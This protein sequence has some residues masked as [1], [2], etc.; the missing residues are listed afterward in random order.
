ML[1]WHPFY[2]WST[3][4][5]LVPLQIQGMLSPTVVNKLKAKHHFAITQRLLL[6]HMNLVFAVAIL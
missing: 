2:N 4:A 3:I 6:R 1:I 5:F